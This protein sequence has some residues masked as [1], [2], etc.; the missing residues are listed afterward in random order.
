MGE[1]QYDTAVMRRFAGINS[2]VRI[3]RETTI[4]N[5]RRLLETHGLGAKMLEAVNVHLQHHGLSLSAGT[6]LDAMI[7]YAPSSTRNADKARIR[8]CTRPEGAVGGTWA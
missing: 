7:I 4:P 3:P 1:A 6:I 5:F 8:R 2:L